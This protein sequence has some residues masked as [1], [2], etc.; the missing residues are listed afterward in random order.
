MRT[1]YA[2]LTSLTLFNTWCARAQTTSP[3]VGH[4]TAPPAVF[5]ERG[6]GTCDTID[7]EVYPEGTVITDQ[8]QS[9]GVVFEDAITTIY[10][11]LYGSVIHNNPTWY[12]AITMRFVDPDDASI[13]APVSYVSFGNMVDPALSNEVDYITVKAYDTDGVLL[14]FLGNASPERVEVITDAPV[15][16][17]IVVDDSLGTAYILDDIVIAQGVPDAVTERTSASWVR[18]FPDPFQDEVHVRA[19]FRGSRPWITD[20][21]GR[22]LSTPMPRSEESGWCMDLRSLT[23]GIYLLHVQENERVRTQRIVK[24]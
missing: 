14:A 3:R 18:V 19:N 8:L 9:C 20:V 1:Y 7:F 22:S 4:H 12:E 11:G 5:E 23:S 17:T 24:Q 13:P 10:A 15:I 2:L 6:G 16:A 21:Q